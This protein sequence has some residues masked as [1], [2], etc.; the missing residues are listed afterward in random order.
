MQVEDLDFSLREKDESSALKKLEVAKTAL[1]T[2]L[3][4][5]L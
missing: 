2:V 4:S 1:D 3:A 5:V